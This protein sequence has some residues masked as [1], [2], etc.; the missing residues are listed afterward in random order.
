MKMIIIDQNKT[1]ISEDALDFV[2]SFHRKMVIDFL[3]IE[4]IEELSCTGLVVLQSGGFHK[5]IEEM[6]LWDKTNSLLSDYD[7]RTK[8]EKYKLENLSFI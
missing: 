3:S 2:G 6:K 8:D 1:K 4:L 7:F 5:E